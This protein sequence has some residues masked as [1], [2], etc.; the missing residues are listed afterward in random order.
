[1]SGRKTYWFISGFVFISLFRLTAEGNQEELRDLQQAETS[2]YQ[3]A[4]VEYRKEREIMV[5]DQ[6]ESYL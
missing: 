1:M 5:D 2:R 3:E 4:I 6:I